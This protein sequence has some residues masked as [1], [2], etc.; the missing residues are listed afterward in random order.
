MN[1]VRPGRDTIDSFPGLAPLTWG[2]MSWCALDQLR[3]LAAE[4]RRQCRNAV[5]KPPVTPSYPRAGISD[6]VTPQRTGGASAMSLELWISR[7][8]GRVND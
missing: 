6:A 3:A 8:L 1:V 2:Q 4:P 7:S 5:R